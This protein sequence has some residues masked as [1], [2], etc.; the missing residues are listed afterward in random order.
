M[1][2]KARYLKTVY[3]GFT[4]FRRCAGHETSAED[5]TDRRELLGEDGE[6]R[7]AREASVENRRR[8][9]EERENLY[10]MVDNDPFSGTFGSVDIGI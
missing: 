10:Q 7:W 9:E 2:E 4:W 8:K 6:E 3:N 1:W 5:A